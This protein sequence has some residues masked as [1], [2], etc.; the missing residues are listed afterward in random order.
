MNPNFKIRPFDFSEADYAAYVAIYNAVHPEANRTVENLRFLDR[1]R[2]PEDLLTRFLA[3]DQG[4]V[5]GL[6]SYERP[7]YNPGPDRHPSLRSAKPR[8]PTPLRGE[9]SISRR[10]AKPR[11]EVHYRVRPGYE[12]LAEPLWGF[13]M[14][15]LRPHT[16]TLLMTQGREDWPEVAFYLRQGFRELDRMW[17][18]TL[19]LETFDPKP[20]ERPLPQGIT[21][22]TLSELPY[23]DK[24]WLRQHYELIIELL[25]SVPSAEPVVPWDFETW[26]ERTLQSPDLLPEGYFIALEGERQVGVSQLWK[27]SRP[28]TLQTGLTGVLASYRRRGIALAL[29][30]QA[31][32]FA[33]AYGVRYLRTNNHSVNRPMLAINEAMGFVKEPAFVTLIQ[34]ISQ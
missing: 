25:Q 18:S 22:S 21:L 28:Q 23:R 10:S 9:R 30:L 34:E 29:K 1:T 12:A 8:H 6:V 3:E 33:K 20:L 24:A 2:K 7:F 4:Q 14:E 31:A 32:R 27:S 11:L 16:P 5:V 19:D 13:L 15:Q 17:A 26:L